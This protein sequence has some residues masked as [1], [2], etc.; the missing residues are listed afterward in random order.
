MPIQ[1]L[2]N[3]PMLGAVLTMQREMSLAETEH[4]LVDSFVRRFH[5]ISGVTELVNLKVVDDEP[6]AYRVMDRLDL[7]DPNLSSGQSSRNTRWYDPIDEVPIYRHAFMAEIVAG[8]LPKRATEVDLSTVPG[9]DGWIEGLR[10]FVAIPLFAEGRVH[11]WL[12][13]LRQDSQAPNPMEIRVAIALMNSLSRGIELLV[14]TREIAALNEKLDGKLHEVARVQQSILPKI[15]PSHHALSLATSYRPSEHAGGDYY[16]F[17]EFDDGSFG[18]AVADVSGHGPAAAVVM[19]MFR[20]AMSIDRNLNGST[21]AITTVINRYLWDG[22]DDGTFVTAFFLRIYPESGKAYYANAG[23]WPALVRRSDGTVDRLDEDASPPI[24]VLPELETAG[25]KAELLPGDMVLLYTDGIVEAF[26]P[27]DQQF[28]ESRLIDVMSQWSP[29]EPAGPN[30]LLVQIESALTAH[31]AG[32]PFADDR[33]MVA[34]GFG[35]RG[36]DA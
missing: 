32:I 8:E 11:E 28:G 24:G 15:K 23:H 21:E 4:E 5:E 10:N 6:G 14:L 22:L 1:T 16:D 33:C 19:A 12:L 29:D 26:N 2:D 17:R 18:I 34:L 25:G 27:Q 7:T 31:A 20:T 36:G 13:M 35:P 9:L 3:V 30:G